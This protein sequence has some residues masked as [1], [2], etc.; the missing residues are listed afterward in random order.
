L[1]IKLWHGSTYELIAPKQAYSPL[2]G[3]NVQYK[4]VLGWASAGDPNVQKVSQTLKFTVQ[5][6]A[7]CGSSQA[8]NEY[9]M[10]QGQHMQGFL[11][12]QNW[13]GIHL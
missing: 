5:Q 8:E 13:N 6:R 11:F 2:L 12:C 4:Q 3:L 7:I 9:E 10:C 1:L